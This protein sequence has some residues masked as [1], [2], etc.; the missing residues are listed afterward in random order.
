MTV[1]RCLILIVLE[2]IDEIYQTFEKIVFPHIFKHLKV[3]Q[4]YS[5]ARRTCNSLFGVWKCG[6][7][8]SLLFDILLARFTE[9]RALRGNIELLSFLS[10]RVHKFITHLHAL[11]VQKADLFN[12][13]G[14]W[15]Q[16]LSLLQENLQMLFHNF[17]AV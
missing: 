4:K 16:A 6:K 15:V 1:F 12:V 2:S 17:C 3:R 5:A 11:H 9:E 13:L 14:F 7:P 10:L 8:R